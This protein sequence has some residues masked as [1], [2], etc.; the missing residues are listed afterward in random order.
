MSGL[1][2]GSNADVLR[3]YPYTMEVHR[4]DGSVYFVA[5]FKSDE[6]SSVGHYRFSIFN[7]VGYQVHADQYLF[8][9]HDDALGGGLSLLKNKKYTFGSS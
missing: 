7:V 6:P 1:A 5:A 3:D 2:N 9:T 4:R 8:E